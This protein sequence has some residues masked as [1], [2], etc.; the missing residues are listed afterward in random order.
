M[1]L[2]KKPKLIYH[3]AVVGSPGDPGSPPTP[4]YFTD[5]PDAGPAIRWVLVDNGR[6]LAVSNSVDRPP[7]VIPIVIN[8]GDRVVPI[9]VAAP[10]PPSTARVWVPPSPGRPAVPPVQGTAASTESTFNLGWNS[11]AISASTQDGDLVLELQVSTSS[12]G[13]VAGLNQQYTS[14]NYKKIGFGFYFT[15]GKVA[16]Y[17]TGVQKTAAV[18]FANADKFQVRRTGGVVSYYQGSTLLHTS[19]VRSSGP[20]FADSSLYSAGDA[21]TAATLAAAAAPTTKN[22]E[23]AASLRPLAGQ[24]FDTATDYTESQASLQPLM[25]TSPDSPRAILAVTKNAESAASLPA[26]IGRSFDNAT[27]Y[28]ESRA[29]FLPLRAAA[30]D[31]DQEL[32][33]S[34]TLTSAAF[35]P[36]QGFSVMQS[37]KVGEVSAA[38]KPLTSL[39]S[40][41]SYTESR[42]AFGPIQS[43]ALQIPPLGDHAFLELPSPTLY[44]T[45]HNSSGENSFAYTLPMPM[46]A[47][48]SGGAALLTSPAAVLSLSATLQGWGSGF[49]EAPAAVI[50]AS[51]SINH[52][53]RAN[54]TPDLEFVLAG[55]GGAVCAISTGGATIQASSSWRQL[56]N[57]TLTLPLFELDAFASLYV[58]NTAA[59]EMPMPYL[60]KRSLAWLVAPPA[61]LTAIGSAVVAVS[62]EAYSVNL[63]HRNQDA[64]DEVTR[65]TNFPFERIVR[66]QGSYFGMA[67]DGLYLLEGTTDD[68]AVIPYSV[69][70]CV[71]DLKVAEKKNA[72]SVYLAGRIGPALTV[73][74]HAG[75]TGQESYAYS[76]LRG[77]GARNHRE[78]F[79]RGVKNRY[80]AL[81]LA[82]E[83][84][85]ELDSIELEVNKTKRKI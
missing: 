58:P 18:S 20:L 52:L 23:G 7:P 54:I 19:A 40:D 11:G 4:G 71:D 28:A 12:V 60:V 38:F 55:Y 30:A 48:R 15:D 39:A 27:G 17:E 5:A 77:Q 8:G 41:A 83:D 33:P 32:R 66:F 2:T 51:A 16:V 72:A 61:T 44:G 45:A 70:T 64:N 47:M 63:S 6:V 21:I 75:E 29:Y 14:N 25:A 24:S 43:F 62:Y 31:S 68:G 69:K 85:L 46:L 81:G 57:A 56:S 79:A 73:T 80:F 59:L 74:L 1:M 22:A 35:L 82:G 3:P 84:A 36:L 78:K 37:G 10:A 49:L 9:W 76:T 67:A 50:V 65:Y 34:Y 13:I 26:L 53:A 42:G